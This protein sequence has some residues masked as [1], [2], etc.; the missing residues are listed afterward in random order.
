MDLL[1]Y[2]V[3]ACMLSWVLQLHDRERRKKAERLKAA[4]QWTKDNVL[5]NA[6]FATDEECKRG[7]LFTGKGLRLAFTQS[8]QVLR[9]AGDRHLL[10]LGPSGS[11]KAR[12][13]IVS[14]IL[15]VGQVTLW[16]N[17]VKSQL[18][19]ICHKARLRVGPVLALAPFGLDSRLVKAGVRGVRYNPMALLKDDA[20]LSV[21]C[22]KIAE[23]LTPEGDE[24]NNF[25]NIRSK[26]LLT[27]LMMSVVC[28]GEPEDRNLL[29]ISNVLCGDLFGY[30]RSIVALTTN[31]YIKAHLGPF[32]AK[33]AEDQRTIQDTVATAQANTQ[34]IRNEMIGPSLLASDFTF[35]QLREKP[36]SFFLVLPADA[37]LDLCRQF[38]RLLLSSAFSE[39]LSEECLGM[40]KVLFVIDEAA[41]LG[42]MK[43]LEQAVTIA[44]GY[45][46]QLWTVWTDLSVMRSLYS[47]RYRSL[48]A[49][50][51]IKL[52]F[53]TDDTATADEISRMSGQAE[54]VTQ[55]HSVHVGLDG[56]PSVTGGANQH[57][58]ALLLPHEVSQLPGDELLIFATSMNVIRAKRKPYWKTHPGKFCPDPFETKSRR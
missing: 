53:P 6:G 29:A 27:G 57:A 15:D 52:V 7:E 41:S 19:H 24:K 54:V 31:P 3:V 4:Y 51:G 49:N 8:G 1:S 47:D 44:R 16:V 34:F 28:H 5:G 32:A 35:R 21:R 18:L 50:A 36:S 58:R 30:C 2:F 20:M 17:D 22:E 26:G 45:G 42:R 14:A 13:S 46:V 40:T 56:E 37:P 10:T 9:Y 38:Y 55:S 39:L 33:G 25:W 43:V 11:G 23:G 12:D 48:L